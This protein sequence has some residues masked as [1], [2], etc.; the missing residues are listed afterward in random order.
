MNAEGKAATDAVKLPEDDEESEEIDYEREDIDIKNI[1]EEMKK[2]R[3]TIEA[4]DKSKLGLKKQKVFKDYNP[5]RA[6]QTHEVEHTLKWKLITL[7]S[8]G[9]C[10]VGAVFNV[11]SDDNAAEFDPYFIERIK[12]CLSL[13]VEKD[14]V[15]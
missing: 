6:I 1:V 2:R 5:L 10:V 9:H 4:K 14:L 15:R 13:M 3:L 12:N 11:L 8:R 7:V